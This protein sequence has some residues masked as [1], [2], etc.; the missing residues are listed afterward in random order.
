M[1]TQI[2]VFTILSGTDV[3]VGCASGVLLAAF[4]FSI[5]A[6]FGAHISWVVVVDRSAGGSIRCGAFG[7]GA[8]GGN[9]LWSGR[10]G[11]STMC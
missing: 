1:Y 5:A 6:G 2:V 9:S 8:L 11:G 4:L 7:H 3:I 10:L